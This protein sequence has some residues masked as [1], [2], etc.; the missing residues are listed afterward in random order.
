MTNN[1]FEARGV[2]FLTESDKITTTQDEQESLRFD[3]KKID[4]IYNPEY[5]IL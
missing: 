2:V 5:D 1:Y 4:F 3:V